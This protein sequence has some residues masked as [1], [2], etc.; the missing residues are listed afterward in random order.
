MRDESRAGNYIYDAGAVVPTDPTAFRQVGTK[1]LAV[2]NPN[3]LRLNLFTFKRRTYDVF[4]ESNVWFMQAHTDCWVVHELDV[5][6]YAALFVSN[7]ISPANQ[8]SVEDSFRQ[9]QPMDDV[10]AAEAALMAAGVGIGEYYVVLSYRLSRR[11]PPREELSADR[12]FRNACAAAHYTLSQPR[13]SESCVA[14]PRLDDGTATDGNGP[15]GPPPPANGNCRLEVRRVYYKEVARIPQVPDFEVRW[16]EKEVRIGRCQVARISCPALYI[17]HTDLVA[18]TSVMGPTV[19]QM[20]QTAQRCCEAALVISVVVVILSGQF[21]GFVP[22]FTSTVAKCLEY[23]VKNEYWPCI[24]P[25]INL[26]R[27]DAQWT[28][29]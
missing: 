19:A 20:E 23:Y 10:D 29:V 18:Y 13:Q 3:D 14:P 25:N 5:D 11:S 27:E 17:R 8:Q 6:L 16:E 12:L 26:Y 2:T 21:E 28:R 7:Q 9:Y 1:S 24:Q 4:R 22:T 15:E